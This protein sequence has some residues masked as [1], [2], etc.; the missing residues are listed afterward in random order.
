MQRWT[1]KRINNH[2]E[3]IPGFGYPFGT[4][5][6][7]DYSYLN[8]TPEALMEGSWDNHQRDLSSFKFDE[9]LD[10]Q[11]E[12]SQDLKLSN[13]KIPVSTSKM[14]TITELPKGNK[15]NKRLT[16]FPFCS[17]NFACNET[18]EFLQKMNLN[19]LDEVAESEKDM[20]EVAFA[21]VAFLP[22]YS[23]VTYR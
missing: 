5:G 8:I 18:L 20:R 21:K 19:P 4:G 16:N 7:E 23:S 3:H 15:P 10:S 2:E 14:L 9:R 11:F 22:Q 13:L 6:F 1:K 17:G 12:L